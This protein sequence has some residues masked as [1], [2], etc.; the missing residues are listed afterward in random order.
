MW[1]GNVTQLKRRVF[2][3]S[4]ENWF[5]FDHVMTVCKSHFALSSIWVRLF[6][7]TSKQ[8]EGCV[9]SECLIEQGSKHQHLPS[10]SVNYR[11]LC[12]SLIGETWWGGGV[13]VW[14]FCSFLMSWHS[15]RCAVKSSEARSTEG[16]LWRLSARGLGERVPSQTARY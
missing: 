8:T 11:G 2:K 14:F 13:C 4:G 6:N 10:C 12:R 16:S 3:C 9:A 5:W 7:P 15:Q 1:Q